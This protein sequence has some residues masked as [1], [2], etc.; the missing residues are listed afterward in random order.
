MINLSSNL[1]RSGAL[2]AN[3]IALRCGDES[4]S[5]AQLQVAVARLAHGLR[6]LGVGVGDRVALSCPNVIA[7]P[8]GYYA[9]LQIGAVVVP[10]NILL[11]S[12]EIAYHLSDAGARVF[13]CFDGGA[14]LATATE[15][16]KAFDQ[17]PSCE[18]FVL[19]DRRVDTG[20]AGAAPDATGPT[21]ASLMHGKP[22]QFETAQ[23]SGND[24]AVILYTSGTTGTPKGAELSHSNVA[25][26]CL[27][28][29]ALTRLDSNDVQLVALP[30]FHSFGQTVQMNATL[31]CGGCVVLVPRFDAKSVLAAIC[32]QGITVFCGV[33]T[34]YVALLQ[35]PDPFAGTGTRQVAGSLR[36]GISGGAP[37]PVAVLRAFE[38][39]FGVVVLEGYGLSET[40]PVAT[41]NHFDSQRVPGS[42][43]QPIVGVEV[44]IVDDAGVAVPVNVDGQ[45][46]VRGHNVMK[47]YYGRPAET[48]AAIVAGWFHTGDIGHCD[49]AGNFFVVDRKKD[50]IIRGGFN[51]YP[52]ELEEVLMTH[53]AV[54][55]VAVLGVPH[56][57]HG[58][59]V[60]AVIV[61]RTAQAASPEE[62]VAWCRERMAAYKYPRIVDVV[63]ALPM[64]ASGKILKRALRSPG[65]GG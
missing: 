51:I 33:P 55:L 39:R 63:E 36:V 17:V 20:V 10:L 2:F 31:A 11:R 6:T 32:E 56:A 52:R 46:V 21:L 27:A 64:T 59:E 58:E 34:M 50:M 22:D 40:S 42:V 44:A 16:R 38:S 18:H 53:P 19:I 37:L 5:Y 3:R 48:L 43:G 29:A 35:L 23:T 4:M 13:L 7:F 28:C 14:E 1:K 61:L 45:I 30:L 8:V 60:R 57:V 49:S 24:T 12:G 25:M 54:A 62:L 26:N 9:I 41:F 65:A 15:G 47:G